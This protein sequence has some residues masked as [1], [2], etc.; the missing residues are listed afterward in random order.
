MAVHAGWTR[1]FRLWHYTVSYSQLL[2][3]SI[4]SSDSPKRID[5]LFSNVERMHIGA[6]YDNFAV[7]EMTEP[8]DPRFGELGLRA[9]ERRRI[10]LINGGPDYVAATHCR[11]H[12]DDGD[13]RSSSKFGPMRLRP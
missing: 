1:E 8:D 7:E 12:E 13:A 2:F 5:L 11:W 3:R 10:F 6:E 4:D 9:L